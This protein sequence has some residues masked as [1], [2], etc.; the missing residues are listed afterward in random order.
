[1]SVTHKTSYDQIDI[2]YY[3]MKRNKIIDSSDRL[4][5]LKIAQAEKINWFSTTT[6]L[7]ND[8]RRQTNRK[9]RSVII[10]WH[11]ISG[12]QSWIV[13]LSL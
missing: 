6:F 1:M 8:L 9:G 12:G 13:D 3:L 10:K 2:L 7:K 5:S 4:S 11:L